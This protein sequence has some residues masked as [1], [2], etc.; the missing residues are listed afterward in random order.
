MVAT[1]EVRDDAF[2]R[3]MAED[4][5]V[6]RIAAGFGFTE[7]PVWRGDHLLFSDIPNNR[8]VRWRQLP[9]GPE[10]TTFRYPAC[11][12]VGTARG[13]S[14]GLTLDAEGRL[15]AC[16]H[17]GRRL[18][19]T[20]PDGAIVTL[21]DTYQGQRLNS[22]NDVVARADGSIYFTDPPYGLKDQREEKE[23]PHNGVYRRA[24]DGALTL[25]VDDFERPNGLAISPDGRTLYVDD[26]ARGHIRAFDLRADGTV[27]NGRVF[28]DLRAAERGAPDGMKLDVEGNVWCTGSGGVWVIAPDGTILGRIL[29]P[30]VT[31]NLAWGGTD[32]R[33]LYLTSST[34][35]CRLE[36]RIAGQPLAAV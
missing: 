36:C 11:Q 29:M 21:A 27:G 5:P 26:T 16:E 12:F 1:Y 10:V 35:V 33:T 32:N 24:P 4:A 7:G 34:S 17:G 19:R 6:Q 13:G 22:P 14:N 8:I 25:L 9:E 2:R 30:E 28:A 3:L 31:A 18:S 23:L 20:E 15:L